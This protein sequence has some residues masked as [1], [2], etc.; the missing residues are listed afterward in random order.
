M[1]RTEEHEVSGSKNAKAHFVWRCGECKRVSWAKFELSSPV[2]A[3]SSETGQFEPLLIIECRGLEF[4]GFDP[5]GTWRCVGSS[6]TVFPD[7]DLTEGEWTDYDEKAALPV[8]I[9][10]VESRWD[11]A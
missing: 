11:R 8:N 10:N 1:N 7:V 6:G 4:V 3:Y 2:K 5:M 9:S